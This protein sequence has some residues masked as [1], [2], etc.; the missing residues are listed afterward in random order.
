MQNTNTPMQAAFANAGLIDH[1]E[2][3]TPFASERVASSVAFALSANVGKAATRI[4]NLANPKKGA[5]P[6]SLAEIKAELVDCI[7][8]LAWGYDNVGDHMR[9]LSECVAEWCGG[10]YSKPATDADIN[11]AAQFLGITAEQAKSTAEA[12]RLNRTSYLTIRRAG[13][14][15]IMEAKINALLGQVEEGTEPD[16]ETIEKACNQVFSQSV[17]WGNWADAALAK[18]DMVYHC[19]KSPEMP[20]LDAAQVE[21]ANRIKDELHRRQSEQA[22]RDAQT[23][24]AFDIDLAA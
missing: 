2:L 14:A 4:Q 21:K 3:N 13:L 17:M 22:E 20:T 15:P 23:L 11:N 18:A 5:T 10:G 16:T 6:D 9:D 12:Q 24:A 1:A 19:G 7:R 8:R